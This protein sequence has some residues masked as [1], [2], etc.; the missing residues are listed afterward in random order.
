MESRVS[1]RASSA[2]RQLLNL[3]PALARRREC[4]R[5][6]DRSPRRGIANG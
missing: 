1:A 5:D 3:A 4:R 2:L 6:G